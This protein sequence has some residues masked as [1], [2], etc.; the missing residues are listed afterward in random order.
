MV[1]VRIRP[2][3]I[4]DR[5][6]HSKKISWKWETGRPLRRGRPAWLPP[7]PSH[8]RNSGCESECAGVH[9]DSVERECLAHQP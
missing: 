2:A 4:T 5:T 7:E 8:N 9:H 1:I 6:L 3:V